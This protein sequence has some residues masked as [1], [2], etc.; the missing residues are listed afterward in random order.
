M[1]KK[2][3][4]AMLSMAMLTSFTTP[5]FA[6]NQG[7]SA[8]SYDSNVT[9]TYVAGD[10]SG[11]IY[12]VDITWAGLSFTYEAAGTQWNPNKHSRKNSQ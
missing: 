7:V 11:T 5:V 9:G 3:F 4:A 8:G 2:F 6:T 1:K 12:S 10:S